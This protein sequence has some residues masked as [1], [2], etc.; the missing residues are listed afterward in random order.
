[1]NGS[2]HQFPDGTQI[3]RV[4]VTRAQWGGCPQREGGWIDFCLT[5]APCIPPAAPSV[6]VLIE[7]GEK[8]APPQPG[9]EGTGTAPPFLSESLAMPSLPA[10]ATADASDGRAA[11]EVCT[12]C[13]STCFTEAQ[14]LSGPSTRLP[15]AVGA[16]GTAVGA[17]AADSRVVDLDDLDLDSLGLIYLSLTSDRDR[18]SFRATSSTLRSAA[19]RASE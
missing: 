10:L 17:V 5:G 16:V 15:E 6:Q 7:M 13:T 2:S 9:P 3:D 11:G 14:D 1:M 4:R 19:D 12:K 8:G 18:H